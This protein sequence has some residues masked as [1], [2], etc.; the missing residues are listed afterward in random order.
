MTIAEKM[1]E[2][3]GHLEKAGA[4]CDDDACARSD[5]GEQLRQAKA[6]LE[7]A[8]KDLGDGWL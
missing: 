4:C 6:L 3:I 5:I 8:L 1:K 2:A 7:A